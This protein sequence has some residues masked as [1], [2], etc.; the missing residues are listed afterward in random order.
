MSLII[1][2]VSTNDELQPN[3]ISYPVTKTIVEHKNKSK[4]H[5]QSV[6]DLDRWHNELLHI[7]FHLCLALYV[8]KHYLWHEQ[9]S[10]NIKSTITSR[11]NRSTNFDFA[12][13]TCCFIEFNTWCKFDRFC[14]QWAFRSNRPFATILTDNNA[15]FHAFH[16]HS[17]GHSNAKFF[18]E[19]IDVFI[20]D[21]IYE[22]EKT[23]DERDK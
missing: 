4:F 11:W 18:Q 13:I 23:K 10:T 9:L 19:F 16:C 20:V 3:H 6:V 17:L 15:R 2:H 5:S 8:P 21:L 22:R 12:T 7:V 14:F 1:R